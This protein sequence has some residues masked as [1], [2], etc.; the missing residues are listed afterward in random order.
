[1]Y[2]IIILCFFSQFNILNLEKMTRLEV[3]QKTPVFEKW[4][5]KHGAAESRSL[6]I[7]HPDPADLSKFIVKFH[8]I[9]NLQ[10]IVIFFLD[11]YRQ[12]KIVGF[13]MPY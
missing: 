8:R 13:S 11:L 7:V 9:N 10:Y 4:K 2:V 12:R 6:S 1:M 3:G 5:A